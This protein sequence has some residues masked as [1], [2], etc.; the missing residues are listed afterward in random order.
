MVLESTDG[1]FGGIGSMFFGWHALEGDVVFVEGIFQSLR[2]F[3]VENVEFGSM[4]AGEKTVVGRFPGIADAGSLA[5]GN[6]DGVNGV[7]VMVIKNKNII[8]ATAGGNRKLAGL[9]GIGFQ[10]I[11]LSEERSTD[12]MGLWFDCGSKVEVGFG[13]QG[14]SHDFRSHRWSSEG[15]TRRGAEIFCFLIL[16]AEGCSDAGW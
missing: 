14:R 9:I 3:V 11:G 15:G 8:V 6:G 4:T 1:S 13:S 16:V 12:V 5:I 2:T 7:G 10:E